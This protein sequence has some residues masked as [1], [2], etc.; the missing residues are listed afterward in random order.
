MD[1]KRP[2]RVRTDLM[3]GNRR[4]HITIPDRIPSWK[5]W[6]KGS[7]HVEVTFYERAKTI[8]LS[9]EETSFASEMY[10]EK[11]DVT[12]T[13]MVEIDLGAAITLRNQ[14]NEFIEAATQE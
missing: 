1:N 5:R 12:K 14:L 10:G 7:A 4:L 11:R 13:T 9:V 2:N 6:G 8:G 3:C